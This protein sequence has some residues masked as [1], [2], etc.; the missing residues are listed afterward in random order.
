MSNKL[1][2]EFIVAQA[3]SNVDEYII[4]DEKIGVVFDEIPKRN[5]TFNM[6]PNYISSEPMVFI[7]PDYDDGNFPRVVT[8]SISSLSGQLTD[9]TDVNNTMNPILKNTLSKLGNLMHHIVNTESWMNGNL[10]DSDTKEIN[11]FIKLLSIP[12]TP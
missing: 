6:N 1:P 10:T 2:K 4:R 7:L 12:D 3:I 8:E 9:I 11:D 5:Y